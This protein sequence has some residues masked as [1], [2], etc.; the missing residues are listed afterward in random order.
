MT[1][2]P[3][4]N[5]SNDNYKQFIENKKRNSN[6]IFYIILIVLLLLIAFLISFIVGGNGFSNIFSQSRATSS[7]N[8]NQSQSTSKT[9]ISNLGNQSSSSNSQS[10]TSSVSSTSSQSLVKGGTIKGT[11]AYPSEGVP[12]HR[13]CAET[14]T[15]PVKTICTADRKSLYADINKPNLVSDLNYSLDVPKGV[16]YVYMEL[17]DKSQNN[18]KAYFTSCYFKNTTINKTELDKQC[19]SSAT[20][21]V[22]PVTVSVDENEI[23]NDIYTHDWYNNIKK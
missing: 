2:A 23:V 1:Q 10:F 4:N 16:Y 8:S 7:S 12:E 11:V 21:S 19:G 14:V 9:S 15:S 17:V 3:N 5:Q 13:V 18:K 20:T 6:I 22:S